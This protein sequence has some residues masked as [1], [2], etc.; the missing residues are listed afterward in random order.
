[1]NFTHPVYVLDFYEDFNGISWKREFINSN[2]VVALT[3]ASTQGKQ[4][5]FDFY[6]EKEIMKSREFA[7]KFWDRP[8]PNE[9]EVNEVRNKFYQKLM[10]KNYPLC[11]PSAM[12]NAPTQRFS[13]PNYMPSPMHSSGSPF[14]QYSPP[15]LSPHHQP[16]YEPGPFMMAP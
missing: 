11:P 9:H 12:Q 16:M 3:Y 2:K 4:Q 7:P 1:M 14:V 5:N 6:K 8:P 13:Y 15:Q 10:A